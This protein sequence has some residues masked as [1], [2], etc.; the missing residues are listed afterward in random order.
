MNKLNR[1][2]LDMEE[3]KKGDIVINCKT[4]KES[5]DLFKYLDDEGI[6]WCSRDKLTKYNIRNYEFG[7]ETCY[8]FD[9]T[10]LSYS[11]IDFYDRYYKIYEWEIINKDIMK[12]WN[13]NTINLENFIK[14]DIAIHCDTLEKAEDLFNFLHEKGLNCESG[15]VLITHTNYKNYEKYICYDYDEGVNYINMDWYKN[16]EFQI[17]EW[18]IIN[19]ETNIISFDEIERTEFKKKI[20]ISHSYSGLEE[21]KRDIEEKVK[22]L[23]KEYPNYVFI[24]PVHTFSYL[25][26]VY[27]YDTGIDICI[28]LLKMCDEMWIIDKGFVNSKGVMVEREYCLCNRIPVKLIEIDN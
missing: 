6:I 10:G 22:K 15:S 17:Y 14:R 28:E 24:S 8:R 11:S 2:T 26:D 9:E 5:I 3:F 7:R 19:K 20:Y 21:N 16:Y 4:E 12:I 18:E 23:V 27:P 25:Y 13:K 1:N